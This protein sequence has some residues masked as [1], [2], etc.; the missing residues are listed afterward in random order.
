MPSVTYKPQ[1][2]DDPKT[3]TW[4][5]K[6]FKE[7]EAVEVSDQMAAKAKNNPWFEGSGGDPKVEAQVIGGYQ[8]A[9]S[10]DEIA[11]IRKP[12]SGAIYA[13]TQAAGPATQTPSAATQGSIARDVVRPPA[14]LEGRSFEDEFGVPEA[15]FQTGEY[16]G[17]PKW[18]GPE[19][20]EGNMQPKPRGRPPGS[21][22]PRPKV[23]EG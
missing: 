19:G 4:A 18:K 10:G 20:T 22:K 13:G 8:D 6:T 2:E 9:N 15:E 5:G 16:E 7:G 23:D 11:L 3:V 17:A 12:G 1:S 21:G 14:G